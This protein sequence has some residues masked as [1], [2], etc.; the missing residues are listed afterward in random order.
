MS[1]RSRM[2]YFRAVLALY[3][4]DWSRAL[5]TNDVLLRDTSMREAPHGAGTSALQRSLAGCLQRM[6]CT[7]LLQNYW[8]GNGEASG[9]SPSVAPASAAKPW[10]CCRAPQ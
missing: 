1:T 4:G 6:G 5:V 2:L 8:R 10:R 7:H 3:A 9:M